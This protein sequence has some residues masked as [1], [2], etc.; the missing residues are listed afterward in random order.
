VI[1]LAIA[2]VWAGIWWYEYDRRRA[3]RTAPLVPAVRLPIDVEARYQRI[4]G[5]VLGLPCL[6]ALLL[7]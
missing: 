5:L 3:L 1:G 4:G 2:A 6:V 7:F